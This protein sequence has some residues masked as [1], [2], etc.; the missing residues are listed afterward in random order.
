M[1]DWSTNENYTNSFLLITLHRVFNV[2]DSSKRNYVQ[3]TKKENATSSKLP[4]YDSLKGLKD[5]KQ[6]L[7]LVIDG[8]CFSYAARAEQTVLK[9]LDLVI[10]PGSITA[11]C[12]R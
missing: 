3:S 10:S 12:G 1:T 4:L 6:S 7:E 8:V 9:G 2:I 5:T 11:I